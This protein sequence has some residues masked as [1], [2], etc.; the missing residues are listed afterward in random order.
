[1][2]EAL[3]LKLTRSLTLCNV[4]GLRLRC[5]LTGSTPK[6]RYFHFG[7][8]AASDGV[9]EA[10]GGGDF[11][12]DS[13]SSTAVCA[14]LGP[15][16][17][18]ITSGTY[19][20]MGAGGMSALVDRGSAGEWTVTVGD[21]A[22]EDQDRGFFSHLRLYLYRPFSAP[23]FSNP[24]L[25]CPFPRRDDAPVGDGLHFRAA[26]SPAAAPLPP[27]RTPSSATVPS[28]QRL[29]ASTLHIR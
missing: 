4:T 29:G 24:P 11:R 12:F 28:M 21:T 22:V 18:F 9:L 26:T 6:C 16:R 5:Q 20:A 3:S 14:G 19:G 8:P 23:P 17:P 25:S 15:E 27:Y 2:F 10:G 13:Q 1:M 7:N